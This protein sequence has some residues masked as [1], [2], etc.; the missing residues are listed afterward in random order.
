MLEYGGFRLKQQV[1]N[2]AFA[3]EERKPNPKLWIPELISDWLEK[4][5]LGAEPVFA[6]LNHQGKLQL[7]SGLQKFLFFE[8]KY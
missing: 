4:L 8:K 2:N 7:F 6:E 5:S 1:G 3:Y